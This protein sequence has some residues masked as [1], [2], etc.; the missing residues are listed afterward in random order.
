MRINMEKTNTM[1]NKSSL[2][3]TV[4]T[5][6]NGLRTIKEMKYLDKIIIEKGDKIQKFD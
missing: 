2:I 3:K 5:D 4:K 6:F 1:F